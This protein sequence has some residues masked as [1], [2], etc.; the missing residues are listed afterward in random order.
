MDKQENK[1]LVKT[2]VKSDTIINWFTEQIENKV[3][4]S[5]MTYLD[6]AMKLNLLLAD[7]QEIL[8]EFLQIVNQKKAELIAGSKAVS[9][10]KIIVEASEE[11]KQYNIQKARIEMIIEHIRLS[12][13]MSSISQAEMKGY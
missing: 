3:P 12:K 10:A 1:K 6:S 7:E 8:Y 5:P 13:K 11:Y 9:A 4:I 2:E